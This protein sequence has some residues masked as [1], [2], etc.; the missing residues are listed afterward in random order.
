MSSLA[1]DD[2]NSMLTSPELLPLALH[3]PLAKEALPDI[4]NHK[5][6][7]VPPFELPKAAS[8]SVSD[9]EDAVDLLEWISLLLLKSPRIDPGHQVDSYLSRYKVP[10]MDKASR[11]DLV[12]LAWK[13]FLPA[14][15]VQQ[16]T[17][18]A[19]YGSSRHC[20]CEKRS[21]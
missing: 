17:L 14:Q 4:E 9:Q 20:P 5:D 7:V 10:C 6:V 12:S 13:G 21:L 1:S 8:L 3:Q 19:L 16:L 18:A 11:Q 2:M 15:W